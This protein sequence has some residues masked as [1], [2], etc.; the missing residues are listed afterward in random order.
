MAMER[1][2][3]PVTDWRAALRMLPVLALAGPTL[4]WATGEALAAG[5]A[6]AWMALVAAAPVSAVA[7]ANTAALGLPA[8]PSAL[9]VLAGT[10]AAPFSLPLVAWL[11]ASGTAIRPGDVFQRAALVVLVPAAT[12]FLLRRSAAITDGRLLRRGDWKGLSALALAALAL[13]RMHGVAEQVLADPAAA[14]WAA[15][16]GVVACGAGAVLAPVLA[17]P[18]GWRGAVLV[19]G[20]KGGALV[21]AVIAPWLPAEG[22]LFMALTILPIYGLPSLIALS[23]RAQPPRAPV[24]AAPPSPTA[25]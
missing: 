21:W 6:A 17:W 3:A 11:F 12:A 4:A 24:C 8:R 13:A 2:G 14:A 10:L 19:G 20:C 5:E 25:R 1:G 23:A 18:S 7:V 9:L 22:H 15:L 16:L